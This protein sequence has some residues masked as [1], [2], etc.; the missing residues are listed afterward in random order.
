MD[1]RIKRAPRALAFFSLLVSA[2]EGPAT[3]PPVAVSGD[4]AALIALE[5]ETGHT[6]TMRRHPL[7]HT[8]A[9]LEGRTRPLASTPRDA[10]RVARD[11]LDRHRALFQMSSPDAELATVSS[12]TD[13]LGTTHTRFVQRVSRVPVVGGVFDRPVVG[14]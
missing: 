4:D 11:F 2:C 12:E 13:E 9:F 3:F 10:E 1:R 6:W 8:P 7:L 5:T 14:S